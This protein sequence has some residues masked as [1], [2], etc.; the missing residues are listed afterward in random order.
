MP[1]PVVVPAARSY[2][3]FLN[4]ISGLMDVIIALV[5]Y[6]GKC[7][8]LAIIW[9][10]TCGFFAALGMTATGNVILSAAKNPHLPGEPGLSSPGEESPHTKV[11]G[12]QFARN[13]T[14]AISFITNKQWLCGLPGWN[15]ASDERPQQTSIL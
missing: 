2:F 1:V 9:K 10:A 11:R 13:E 14:F 5:D 12:V 3:R 15:I 8:I 7:C 6:W 4:Y